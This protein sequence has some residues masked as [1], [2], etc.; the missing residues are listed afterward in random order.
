MTEKTGKR[1]GPAYLAGDVGCEA[2]ATFS[3]LWSLTRKGTSKLAENGAPARARLSQATG[4]ACF[5]LTWRTTMKS[6]TRVLHMGA[7]VLT[8]R[9]T[10]LVAVL[11]SLALAWACYPVID[12]S[13]SNPQNS[14]NAQ[15]SI[16]FRTGEEKVHI[17]LRYERKSEKG[18]H[19]SSHGFT[20]DPSLLSG[21]TREQAMS[22]GAH[23]QFQLKRDAGTFN[24][25]GW[26]KEGNGSGHFTFIP[27]RA[28]AAQ[29]SSQG[30]GSPTDEQLLS[31]AMSDTGFALINELK[32]QGYERPTLNQLVE[33]GNHGVG[34]DYLQGL[35]SYGYQLKTVDGLVKMRDHGV[36]LKFISEMS[37]LGYKNLEPEGLIRIRDHGVTPEFINEMVAAGYPQFSVD[38]WVTL[39]DHGV[40]TKYIKELDGLGYSRLPVEQLREMRDHGVN[41]QFIQELKAQG[42]DRVPVEQLVRLRDHGVTGPYIQKMKER[43]YSNLSLDEYI[44]LRDRGSWE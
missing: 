43:G 14:G 19:S 34:V 21:L 33:M 22:S 3:G 26:F 27:D 42:Y 4:S 32:T 41:P 37:S 5:K 38:E 15:W 8:D 23:V 10:R 39:R 1:V 11:G 30:F 44:N 7:K 28:F 35:K 18:T 13:Y 24:F 20:L 29:L 25:D 2:L 16:E 12:T 40:N 17:E 9:H 6:I 31:L 36:S